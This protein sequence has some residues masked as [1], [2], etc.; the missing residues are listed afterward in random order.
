MGGEE[1]GDSQGVALLSSV[2]PD[3][4]LGAFGHGS[5]MRGHHRRYPITLRFQRRAPMWRDY[6]RQG[7]ESLALCLVCRFG[8]S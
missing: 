7:A 5:P 1:P 2:K 8:V 3:L 6:T 4:S